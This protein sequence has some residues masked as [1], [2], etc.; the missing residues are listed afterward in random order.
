MSAR[1]TVSLKQNAVGDKVKTRDRWIWN[2]SAIL[3]CRR[4]PSVMFDDNDFQRR[5]SASILRLR[6][7]HRRTFAQLC[8]WLCVFWGYCLVVRLPLPMP[9]G[10]TSGLQHMEKIN[11]SFLCAFSFS[12][13]P[14][15]KCPWLKEKPA[16]VQFLTHNSIN[17]RHVHSQVKLIRHFA[18]S[19]FIPIWI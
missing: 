8:S 9:V 5:L 17:H 1:T 2:Y 12:F 10:I 14:C 6:P 7:A 4:G 16:S 18:I 11:I 15:L 3:L 13:D 19:W